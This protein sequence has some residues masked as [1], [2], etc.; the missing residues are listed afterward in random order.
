MDVGILIS[1]SSA[2]SKPNLNIWK[3]SF[4]NLLKPSL[5]DLSITLLACEISAIAWQFEH[6]LALPFFGIGMKTDLFHSCGHCWVFQVYWHIEC[7]TLTA[8][9]FWIW[10]SSVG[11]TSPLLALFLV[12]IP[13]AHLTSHSRMSDSWWVTTSSW[14]YRLLRTFLYSSFVYSCHL[15]SI[16]SALLGLYLFC[17]LLYPTLHEMFPWY[18]QFSWRH[19]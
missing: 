15:F 8:S 4:H 5:K 17:S 2:F 10:N 9:S 6:S 13:K 14:L 19:L 12:M 3:F 18:L 7:S 11:I 16:S 1:D